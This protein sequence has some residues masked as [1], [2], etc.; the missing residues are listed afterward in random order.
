MRLFKSNV[1]LLVFHTTAAYLLPNPAGIY[2]VTLTT[3]SLTDYRRVDPYAPCPTPRALMLSIFQPTICSSTVPVSYMPYTTAE[4]QGPALEQTFNITYDISP[5]FLEAELPVCL[6]DA[7]GSQDDTCPSPNDFPILLFSPGYSIPRL[8]YSL[9]A[10]SIAGEGFTVITIDHP[11][12]ANIIEYPDGSAVYNN[13]SILDSPTWDEYD[14]AADAS[15]LINQLC[16]ASAVASLLPHRGARAFGTDKIGMLGHSAGG[17]SSI[18]AASRDTR[19]KGAINLDGTIFG[20]PAAAG[21]E[22]P[23]RNMTQPVLIMS[24][25]DFLDDSWSASWPFLQGPKMIVFVNGTTHQTFSD[26]PSLLKSDEID[27]SLLADVLG[28]VEPGQMVSIIT[29]YVTAW[30]RGVFEGKVD[31]DVLE[32]LGAKGFSEVEILRRENF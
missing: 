32:A 18:I 7:N 2:N 24:H 9:L 27:P 5:I 3:G 19:I 1:L 25:Q 20:S 4:Y 11:Y 26:V 30:M 10:S 29:G 22:E 31:G 14:R 8:Y 23:V 16:N 15:F 12:D 21:A 13:A 28:S 17:A 6:D